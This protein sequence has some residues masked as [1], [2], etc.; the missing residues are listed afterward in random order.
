MFVRCAMFEGTV[1]AD[2]RARFEALI[3]GPIAGH[4]Q[5]FPGIRRL[6]FHWGRESELEDR[7]IYLAIEHGYDS[8]DDIAT[9]I[10][11]D[12]RRAMQKP[13]DELMALFHGHVY[14]VNYEVAPVEVG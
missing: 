9:A 10:T 13:L 4:M 12:T 1:H 11:S 2:D 7:S 3:N 14:H 6:E 8:L 5:H